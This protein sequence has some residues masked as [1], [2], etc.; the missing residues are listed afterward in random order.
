MTGM[1]MDY[2][3][4]LQH[5]LERAGRLFPNNEIVTRTAT[6]TRRYHYRDYYQR[7]HRLAHALERL[8]IQRG[9]RV[10]TLCWNTHQHLELYFAVTCYGAVLHTLNL[11]LS[12]DDLAYIINHAGDRVIFADETLLPILEKIRDRIPNVEKIIVISGDE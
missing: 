1:M 7:T 4:T 5:F 6:G 2:P 12:P 8:G 9:D 11:R 3:L 10:G